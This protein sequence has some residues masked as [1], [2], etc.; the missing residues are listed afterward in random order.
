MAVRVKNMYTLFRDLAQKN[1][2]TV[3]EQ[4]HIGQISNAEYLDY[5][6]EW[7]KVARLASDK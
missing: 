3:T 5:I 7:L 1:Y 6:E 2:D 4:Y